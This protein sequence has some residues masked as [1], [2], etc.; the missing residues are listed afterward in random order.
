MVERT[1]RKTVKFLHPFQLGGVEGLLPPGSYEVETVEEQLE[2]LSFEAYRR[3]STTITVQGP[4]G[5]SRQLSTIDPI[6]LAAA[7]DRDAEA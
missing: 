1:R 5:L 3:V 7:L 6:D 2:G 4:T